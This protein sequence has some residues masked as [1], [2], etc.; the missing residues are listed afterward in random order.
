M[1]RGGS[2]HCAS[3]ALGRKAAKAS[4][5]RSFRII[6]GVGNTFFQINQFMTAHHSGPGPDLS[7]VGVEG[8]LVTAWSQLCVKLLPPAVVKAILDGRQPEGMMLPEIV[9]QIA[10]SWAA[11]CMELGI[12]KSH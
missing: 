2:R 12:P 11:Q 4:A 3:E 10:T 1:V 7:R 6:A 5:K 9:E 8:S